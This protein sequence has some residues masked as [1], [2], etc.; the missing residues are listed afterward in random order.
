V[1]AI[2]ANSELDASEL[3]TSHLVDLLS[4]IDVS[5]STGPQRRLSEILR[6]I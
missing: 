1:D 2:G 5:E 3:M 6:G 4:G